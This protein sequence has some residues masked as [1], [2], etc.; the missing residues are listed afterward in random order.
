MF[1]DLVD[2]LS[3]HL[4]LKLFRFKNLTGVFG[5]DH[6]VASGVSLG[7]STT[8][9]NIQIKIKNYQPAP[10]NSRFSSQN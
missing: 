10:F 6:I 1:F 7:A 9:E 8:A 3:L 4:F 5:E 2:K